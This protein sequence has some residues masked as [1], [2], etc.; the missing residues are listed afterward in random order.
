MV[1]EPTDVK[2]LLYFT[3]RSL[4]NGG[5]VFAWVYKK[6]CPECHKAIMGKPVEKGKVKMRAP[7]YVCPECGHE[8]EKIAHEDTLMVEAKYTCPECKKEG[9]GTVQYK[10]KTYQGIPSYV[11]DCE[12][13][14]FKIAITKKMKVKK[15]KKK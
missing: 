12:H 11:V 3:N 14:G 5:K 6:E 4:D 2:G 1:T 9:T 10:K 7:I 15:V 13:C 8:E